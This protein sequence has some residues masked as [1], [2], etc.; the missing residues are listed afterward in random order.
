MSLA[1]TTND[2]TILELPLVEATQESLKG[3]GLLVDDYDAQEI[4]IVTWP[5]P[6]WR[7]CDPGTGNEGGVT[8][9]VY[10]DLIW[11][12]FPHEGYDDLLLEG[13]EV[14]RVD[15]FGADGSDVSV[16]KGE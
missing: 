2:I 11:A 9:G 10:V 3:Y 5:V 6:G 12:P 8:E 7:Q 4:E 15:L 13:V 1:S 14:A 16:A